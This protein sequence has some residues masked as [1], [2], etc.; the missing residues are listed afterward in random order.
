MRL[1]ILLEKEGDLERAEVIY[2]G[3]VNKRPDSAIILF[4][5][6]NIYLK[7]DA[8]TSA[9]EYY[10]RSIASDPQ[11]AD[12]YNNLAWVYVKRGNNLKEAEELI[13][14]AL[15]LSKK[16]YALYMDTLGEIYRKRGM[17]E[18]AVSSFKD[19]LG[20]CNN[21]KEKAEV[22]M[23]IGMAYEDMGDESRARESYR[24]AEE[25]PMELK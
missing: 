14:K 12:A 20:R 4:N 17:Y 25:M 13:Q 24:K 22:Y 5:L 15:N 10:R 2:K 6:G 23:H 3:L 18:E 7:R 19:A 11:L 9:E 8:L 16:N 1:A 21:P